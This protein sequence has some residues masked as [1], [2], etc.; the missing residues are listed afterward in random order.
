MNGF[1]RIENIKPSNQF[2]NMFN[3]FFDNIYNESQSKRQQEIVVKRSNL[4]DKLLL[5]N[6]KRL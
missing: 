5:I 6:I 2:C 4:L 1:S 3:V